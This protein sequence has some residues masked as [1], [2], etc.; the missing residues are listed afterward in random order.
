VIGREVKGM[1]GDLKKAMELGK[2]LIDLARKAV[3]EKNDTVMAVI[4]LNYTLAIETI[5]DSMEE[6]S[7]KVKPKKGG[8]SNEKTK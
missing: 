8:D 4:G 1:E 3:K 5:K 6:K 2:E 7:K